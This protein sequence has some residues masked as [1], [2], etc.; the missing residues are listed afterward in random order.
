MVKKKKKKH[1]FPTVEV[2][3]H[4]AVSEAA[5]ITIDKLPKLATITTRGFL[6][7]ETDDSITICATLADDGGMGDCTTIPRPW[8][9]RSKRVRS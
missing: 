4:D 6:V 2:E 7:Q 9:K 3:W 8:V 1:L 5:W